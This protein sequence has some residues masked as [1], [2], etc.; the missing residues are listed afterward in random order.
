MAPGAQT[1][2]LVSP[3]EVANEAHDDQDIDKELALLRESVS[4]GETV[5]RGVFVLHCI[6]L[7]GASNMCEV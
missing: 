4:S 7:G 6:I 2:G 5:G 1:A 3:E